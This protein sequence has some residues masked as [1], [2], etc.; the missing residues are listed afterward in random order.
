MTGKDMRRAGRCSL[1]AG[2]IG[3]VPV[4]AL[5]FDIARDDVRGFIDELAANHGLERP[6]IESLLR[7]AKSEESILE[8]ISRPAEKVKPW[9]EY[10]SIFLTSRRIRGGL[11]FWQDHASRL[12]RVTRNTGVPSEVLAAIIGVETFYG[13]RT[14]SYRVLDSLATLAFDY[15]PRSRFFRAELAELFL[16]AREERLDLASVRGSYAG[17]MGPPQFIPSSYRAYAVDGD[18]DGQRDLLGNWDDILASV[19]NYF[20]AHRWRAGEPVVI[21]VGLAPG[22]EAPQTAN[23][24][25]LDDTLG[26]LAGQ[27]VQVP[28]DLDPA[29]PAQLYRLDGEDGDEYW[30]GFHNFY[31][32]TRYNRSVMYALAVHQLGESIAEAAR[33]Q[34]LLEAS[35]TTS[36]P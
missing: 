13:R 33:A 16:L 4:A 31:V 32:I 9:H 8:A 27:G 7:T 20:V 15:P 34:R 24:L 30:I 5:A 11:E 22:A 18:G 21:R 14:G 2:I 12:T 10:R 19:A 25:G 6:E 1:L 26:S 29:V 3:L 28:G 23:K 36:Q 35:A 17:A